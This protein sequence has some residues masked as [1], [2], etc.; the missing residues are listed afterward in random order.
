[1]LH[2]DE[3]TKQ[4]TVD[5]LQRLIQIESGNPPGNED[6]IAAFIK[7]YLFQKGNQREATTA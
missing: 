7:A 3:E 1:L 2:I 5:L 4:E 6:R